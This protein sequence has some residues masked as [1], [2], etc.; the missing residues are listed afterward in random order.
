MSFEFSAGALEPIVND[1]QGRTQLEHLVA[2]CPTCFLQPSVF[3]VSW[4]GVLTMAYSG[5]P[6]ALI[7]LKAAIADACPGLPPEKAGSKWP[8]VSTLSL[9]RS[10]GCNYHASTVS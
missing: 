9:G 4:Q 7:S 2:S 10:I 8:K 5:F 3:F 1:P 6:P